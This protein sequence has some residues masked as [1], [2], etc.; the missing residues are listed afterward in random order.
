MS[1]ELIEQGPWECFRDAS[2]YDMW[3]VRRVHD[4]TFGH[5]F[6]LM[7][8]EEAAALRDLLNAHSRERIAAAEA[9]REACAK[10]IADNQL[11]AVGSDYEVGLE[12]GTQMALD[13]I[14]AL[15]AKTVLEAEHDRH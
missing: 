15:D 1:E 3:C 7:Q 9:M 10:V 6:H 13:A 2:Y 8:G 5:G 14:R 11:A 4:R 12:N